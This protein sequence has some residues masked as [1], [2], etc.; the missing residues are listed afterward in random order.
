MQLEARKATLCVA[1]DLKANYNQASGQELLVSLE[2][3]A[4]AKGEEKAGPANSFF[5]AAKR[6]EFCDQL[7]GTELSD[8]S[9]RSVHGA[10]TAV[11]A[12]Q[13]LLEKC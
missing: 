5:C 13:R 1:T 8:L 7:A 9:D 11:D 10:L 6:K 12:C 3:Q 4:L 2:W